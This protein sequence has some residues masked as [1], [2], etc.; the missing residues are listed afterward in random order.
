MA[1]QHQAQEQHEQTAEELHELKRIRR[2]KLAELQAAGND[3]FQQVRFERD[4]YTSD[5][6]EHFDELEGKTV[7]LAGRMMSKRI[8][9]KASFS[10][11]TDRYGRLQLY[12]KRDNVGEDVYKGYKKFDIGD[13]IGIE[14]EVF[15]TQKGE[16]SVAVTELTLLSKNLNP[17]PEKWHGLKDTDM[18]YRQRYVDL[19]VNPGV[20]DTFEKRSAIV[21]EI[22]N[23]MDSRGF[24]EVETPCLNTIPGGAAARPFITHHNALDIDM[25]LRI[26][27]ELH[28]KRLI[29]GGLERVYEIGRIFRN[30]GMDTRHNPEFTTIELY[31]AYT[32]YQGMM[33]ITEDMVIHVCEKVL[34]STK[35]MY[36]G[37][38]IDFSKGWKRMTMAEAVKE[39]AGIDFMAL[40]PEE[41]LEAV[42]AKGLE[43]EPGKES[44]GDLMAQCYD[45]YVEANLM[46]PTF[47]TD[48]PVEISPL[49]KRKPSDPRLTERFECFIYGRELCN[50]FSELNDPIDQKGRFERQV[51]LRAAGDEEAGMMDEDFINALEYGMPPTGGMGMGID[52]LVMFLTDAASIRDVLLFPTM[53]PLDSDKKAEK[54][55]P[56][57]A[58]AAQAAPEAE[59]KIDFSNV[60]IE[61]LFQDF[62]DFDTFSKSDFRAVKIKECEAVKKSKKLLKFVLDDGTGEDRV[63]LSGIHEYYE[64]EELVGKTC[65][66]I[67]NLPPRPMMGIDSCGML[68]SAVHHEN[69]EE[70]LHLLMVD[71]HIPA[72]AKL[73]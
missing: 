37:V 26:A 13:I 11:M 31:Q 46:Q 72:G 24:M 41:A 51:A 68:I 32:D 61:P 69:G 55:A 29:V 38:E 59:E 43:I 9:G 35:V 53:K 45:E 52:R 60:E 40:S 5:I 56:V 64:P 39:Y 2:E 4:H 66:A 36:Q 67:T 8:M 1:E 63:I 34:G 21:R 70:K 33:D 49:A 47:I 3:P 17:L 7:R 65:I 50:A 48:Y 42:K 19:I 14:G 6:H 25:Y 58:E 16:I 73:Y 62:V 54:A 57:Q 18:R 10:D 27:T 23:F 30:E 15:R 22:R 20:R 71:P 12:I 28:L 44:W